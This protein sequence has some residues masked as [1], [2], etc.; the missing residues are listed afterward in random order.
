MNGPFG[1]FTAAKNGVN[2]VKEPKQRDSKFCREPK[3]VDFLSCSKLPIGNYI[4]SALTQRVTRR[5]LFRLWH[6]EYEVA[7]L[8]ERRCS[9]NYFCSSQRGGTA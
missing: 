9:L 6:S 1:T 8:L 7:C 2:W 3:V 4:C 5:R